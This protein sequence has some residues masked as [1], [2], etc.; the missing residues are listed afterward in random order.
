MFGENE[1]ETFG[2]NEE[3]F[4]RPES[5]ESAPRAK[6]VTEESAY[7]AKLK[8]ERRSET[9]VLR[10][11]QVKVGVRDP[12]RMNIF[13][14]QRFLCS[15]TLEQFN[16]AGLKVG[17][18]LTPEEKAE[19]VSL[20][21]FG[22][23]YQR[24]LEW[25]LTR[26]HSEWEMRKYL[27]NKQYRREVD[28]RRYEQFLENYQ[29]DA[30]FKAEVDVERKRV[31]ELNAKARETDFT[32]NNTFEYVRYHKTRYP[33]KP[34]PRISDGDIE[35][36]MQKLRA[37]RLLDDENFAEVYV[38]SR[39]TVTG[40]S[41]RRLQQEL[42]QKGVA[43]EVVDK[44]LRESERSDDEEIRKMIASKRRRYPDDQKMIAYLMRQ[45]FEYQA[46]R[47]ALDEYVAQ[48]EDGGRDGA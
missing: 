29:T 19:L 44:V 46:A 23:F 36:V 9:K 33:R 41:T 34:L 30:E 39:K 32:E 27:R 22:K 7:F 11:T 28:W 37:D 45:G 6:N 17:Q 14:N 8:T 16:D 42:A 1:I 35:K 26:P 2:G 10:I 48:E 21:N 15:L 13:V 3:G 12:S 4:R 31:K 40:V 43:R 5:E 18:E 47:Q 20:S 25:A 24:T 38:R